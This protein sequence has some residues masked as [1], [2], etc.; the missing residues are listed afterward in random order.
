MIISSNQI[1]HAL[2]VYGAKRVDKSKNVQETENGQGWRRD[3]LNVSDEARLL[4]ASLKAMR[5]APEVR[6]DRVASL[7]EAL[8]SGAYH[9]T[10]EQIAEKML[11][12]SLADQTD[13][14]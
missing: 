1:Q 7:S 10:G 9:V 4:Q 14:E 8:R 3:S 13:L 2:Q 6:A 5:E 11:G 12:R